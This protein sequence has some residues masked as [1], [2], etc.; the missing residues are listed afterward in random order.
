MHAIRV[1]LYKGFT[2]YLRNRMAVALTFAVPI[3]MIYIFGWVFGLN[4]KDSGPNGIR[5]AVVNE[6]SS[7]AAQKL[8]DVLKAEKA[9]QVVTK[10]TNPDKTTRPLVAADL[11]PL[12]EDGTFRFAVV[13]PKE[14]NAGGSTFGVHLRFLSNPLNEIEAQT[15]NGLLQR[16]IFSHVPELLGQSLQARA[17][18]WI[19]EE[20]FDQFNANLATNIA[21]TFGGDRDQILAAIKQGDFG[22]QR[23]TRNN[24]SNARA[25]GVSKAA[26]DFFSRIISIEQEQVVGREVKSPAAT[27]VVG[28]WAIMFLMFALNGAATSLFEEKKSGLVQR[29]L[30]APVTRAD[31][32][33]AHFLFGVVLG[34]V[35]LVTVFFVGQLFFGIDVTGHLVNLTIVCVAAAAACTA[36]GMF[37]ASVS[38]SPESAMGLA[39]FV[40]LTMSACGGAWF[41]ISF[42]PEFM[43]QFARFTIT[44]WAIDGFAQ[45]LWAGKSLLQLLP[46]V[47]I[48]LGIAIGVMTLAVWRLNHSKIFD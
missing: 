23:F 19:G 22:I 42:M 47:G 1:L 15:V 45:V 44:Y 25:G 12:I 7:P 14:L 27:R 43:Q 29:L 34:L 6:S 9:F 10:F 26:T 32:L 21:D 48:L 18:E 46:T 2:R 20:R 36:L 16:A 30:A 33:W 28:G 11:K 3:A 39:T 37:I 13:I 8:V 24:G 17:R 31:I 5:L 35:Q 4:R 40:V 38:T 41:P